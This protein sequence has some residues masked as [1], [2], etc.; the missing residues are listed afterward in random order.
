M[1]HIDAKS[2]FIVGKIVYYGPGRC[3]KTTNLQQ[4]NQRSPQAKQL[5]SLAT[6]GDRTIFFD[7]M[8][9]D[10]GKIR[11]IDVQFKLYTVP[12]QVKYNRTRKMVLKDV[13]GIVFV[14]DSQRSMRDANIESWQNLRD[15]LTELGI[16]PDTLPIV[17]QYNKRDL[18]E[19]LSPEEL[20]AD[21]NALKLPVHQASAAAGDGVMK[22][23]QTICSR[24]FHNMRRGLSDPEAGDAPAE[25]RPHAGK[26]GKKAESP[27]SSPRISARYAAEPPPPAPAPVPAASARASV[28]TMV[29]PRA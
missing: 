2:K 13:D 23:L 3:G 18:P 15:N 6:E 20:D 8:P 7:F 22:T 14:A 27:A 28:P 21:L 11:G 4:V 12:G 17:L 19:V 5:M 24:V 9:L 1:A 16:D 29:L 25:P 10:V 26:S